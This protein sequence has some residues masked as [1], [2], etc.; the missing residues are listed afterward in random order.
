MV[1]S[2]TGNLMT[3]TREMIDAH[4]ALLAPQHGELAP[5]RQLIGG[6]LIELVAASRRFATTELSLPVVQQR[7][8]TTPLGKACNMVCTLVEANDVEGRSEDSRDA[9]QRIPRP[10]HAHPARRGPAPDHGNRAHERKLAG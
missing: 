7:F 4:L 9:A 3:P 8:D 1:V 2:A 6:D 5:S 10:G